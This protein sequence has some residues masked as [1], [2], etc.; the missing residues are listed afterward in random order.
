[1]RGGLHASRVPQCPEA[2]NKHDS[3]LAS[4]MGMHLLHAVLR[5][6]FC[7]WSGGCKAASGVQRGRPLWLGGRS[8]HTS[9][10][11]VPPRGSGTCKIA[12]PLITTSPST[13]SG[14]RHS[15]C[16]SVFSALPLSRSSATV[17]NSPDRILTLN[18]CSPL[19]STSSGSPT[20]HR[21]AASLPPSPE[22]LFLCVSVLRTNDECSADAL[23]SHAPMRSS[24]FALPLNR[25]RDTIG[26][27]PDR[28]FNP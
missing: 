10:T 11:L 6:T 2:I 27:S 16:V 25:S 21:F 23:V 18:P 8:T 24:L 13:G 5:R 14:D 12:G 17:G 4:A 9:N 28:H 7:G 15:C 26:N 22:P 19:P 3:R 1:M 20:L